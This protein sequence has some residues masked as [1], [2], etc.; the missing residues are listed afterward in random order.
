MR[1]LSKLIKVELKL[2]NN[3]CWFEPPVVCR[4]E[5]WSDDYGDFCSY[6][7]YTNDL[8]DENGDQSKER[9]SVKIQDFDLSNPPL[10][11]NLRERFIKHVIPSTPL[12]FK[13]F[14]EELEEYEKKQKAYRR[15]LQLQKEGAL[16]VVPSTDEFLE[17]WKEEDYP[18]PLFPIYRTL[19]HILFIES[20]REK[21]KVLGG[22]MRYAEASQKISKDRDDVDIG[23]LRPVK[24]EPLLLSEMVGRIETANQKL[25]PN[26]PEDEP[27]V[28][29]EEQEDAT[30]QRTS[31]SR[32]S[33]EVKFEIPEKQKTKKGGKGRGKKLKLKANLK[34]EEEK[35]STEEDER[36]RRLSIVDEVIQE[37][38]RQTIFEYDAGQESSEE[39]DLATQTPNQIEPKSKW[40]TVHIYNQSFDPSTS[41]I[42]FYI[43]KFGKFG[44]ACKRYYHIPFTHWELNPTDEES[45]SFKIKTRETSL[46]IKITENGYTFDVSKPLKPPIKQ[47]TSPVD[48]NKLK[49]VNS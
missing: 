33:T 22:L 7:P 10:G 23:I 44:L 21:R 38:K 41:I 29:P 47:I 46:E 37:W 45:I 1:R 31:K 3:C 17:T 30:S 9:K 42:T 35:T 26:F 36:M 13:L 49:D 15:M 11:T 32:E 24:N 12:R 6:C 14:Y 18:K 25:E 34:D 4:Y 40:R 48:L 20:K 19:S 8:M 27:I 28:D 16:D 5:T 2:P 43:G 39:L